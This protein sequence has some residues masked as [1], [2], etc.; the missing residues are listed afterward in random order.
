MQ[1]SHTFWANIYI[2][3]VNVYKDPKKCDLTLNILLKYIPNYI[4]CYE[5][6]Q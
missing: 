1:K 3:G 4:V 6:C 5:N 2:F